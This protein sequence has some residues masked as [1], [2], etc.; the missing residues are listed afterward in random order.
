M[1]HIL[2]MIYTKILAIGKCIFLI[3]SRIMHGVSGQTHI[4]VYTR[5]YVYILLYYI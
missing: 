4:N 3:E 5:M 1:G 2:D